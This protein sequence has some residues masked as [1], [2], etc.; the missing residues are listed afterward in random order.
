MT[1]SFLAYP[2]EAIQK[3]KKDVHIAQQTIFVKALV[4][5]NKKLLIKRDR[6]YEHSCC[7]AVHKSHQCSKS[8]KISAH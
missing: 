1:T 2:E 3:K 7:G 6:I 8:L 5:L 4:V